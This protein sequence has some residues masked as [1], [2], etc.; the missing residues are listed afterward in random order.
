MNDIAERLSNITQNRLSGET[1][2]SVSLTSER[3]RN[4][5]T[6]SHAKLFQISGPKLFLETEIADPDLDALLTKLE[7]AHKKSLR[8]RARIIS[9]LVT[10]FSPKA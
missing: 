7:R 9:S 10:A 3:K 1:D 5:T 8:A 6:V 4:G 2:Y